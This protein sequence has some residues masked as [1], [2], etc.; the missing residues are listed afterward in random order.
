M[1]FCEFVTTRDTQKK[2]WMAS[3]E[4]FEEGTIYKGLLIKDS[5]QREIFILLSRKDYTTDLTGIVLYIIFNLI[6]DENPR[7]LPEQSMLLM[8]RIQ[9][10]LDLN[11]TE[12]KGL[13]PQSVPD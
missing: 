13:D 1:T 11:F 4:E 9:R 8:F 2:M 6:I 10:F 3:G 5:R 7:V 12:E